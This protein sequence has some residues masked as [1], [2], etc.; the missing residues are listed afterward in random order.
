MNDKSKGGKGMLDSLF[1]PI[2]V[3]GITIKNRIAVPPMVTDYCNQDGTA[4]E[5]F[6]AYHEA[7]AKGGFGLIITEDYAIDPL[8][9][10]FKTVAGLWCDEQIESH[11]ELTKR[12]HAHGAKIIAQIY[13]AGRQTNIGAIGEAPYAPTAIPCPF[14]TDMPREFTTEE[15]EEVIEKFGDA[16]LRA[17]KCGFDGIEIHGGHGYLVAQF[18]SPYSNKR[19]DKFGGSFQNRMH[20]PIEI[21]KNIREK[22]GEDFII[23]MR[24]SAD[25]YVE[26]GRNLQDTLAMVPFFEEAGLD[27]IHV[28]AGTYAACDAIVPSSYH[29]HA[30]NVDAAEAVKKI[31]NIPVIAVGR[32]NDPIIAN[33]I[34]KMGKADFVAMGRASLID[35]DMPNK[36]KEGRYEDIKH[37]IGCNYGCLGILFSDNPIKCVLNPTLGKEWEGPVKNAEVKKNVAVIGAGPAGLTAALTA[38]EAGHNVIVYEKDSHAGGQFYL[39]SIPPCKGEIADYI[40]WQT[41]QCDKQGIE[42]KYNTEATVELMKEVKPD[43]II[44]ATG[45]I[46]SKLPIPGIDH[47]NVCTANDILVGKVFP[48]FNCVVIGGGQVGAETANYLGQQLKN[49]TILEMANDIA[50]DE[51][52]APRWALLKMLE[53]RKVAVKTGAKVKEIKDGSVVYECNGE[54]EIAADTV[55]IAVGSKPNNVLKDGLIEAGFD[56]RTIGDANTIGI[57]LNATEEGFEVGKNI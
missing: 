24:I 22:C 36:A 18:M 55:V 17:K 37:C 23:D 35:P 38:K 57:V 12:V 41:T 53:N 45:A 7:K 6:I 26:G 13:H 8:G 43:V 21:I 3:K 44:M 27:M 1:N 29:P 40:T 48:G 32:V 47:A 10:G 9:R 28:S 51:A 15:A 46:P 25:E 4:S 16:A 54:H 14:G 42:I 19:V 30:W 2:T 33:N 20:F 5:R 49:V 11:S 31:C 34:I 50:V 56:V 39:A 52:L